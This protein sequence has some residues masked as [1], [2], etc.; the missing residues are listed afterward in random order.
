MPNDA[1]ALYDGALLWILHNKLY[2]QPCIASS[3]CTSVVIRNDEVILVII[4]SKKLAFANPTD[5]IF[6]AYLY[7]FMA[8]FWQALLKSECVSKANQSKTGKKYRS[9]AYQP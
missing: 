4:K 6:C 5:P 2:D 1:Q 8:I 9:C 7:V 3:T